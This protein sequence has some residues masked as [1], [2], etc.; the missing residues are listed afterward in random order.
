[1]NLKMQIVEEADANYEK[2]ETGLLKAAL[3]RTP[4]ERYFMMTMLM[5]RSI[6]LKQARITP[7][8]TKKP[9]SK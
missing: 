8:F 9:Q 4:A 3:K 7:Y 6:M 5:K 1:M 2:A